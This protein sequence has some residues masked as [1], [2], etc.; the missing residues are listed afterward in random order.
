M[1]LILVDIV[2]INGNILYVYRD[3]VEGDLYGI[4]Q[5]SA[6]ESGTRQL[7]ATEEKPNIIL[8]R[9]SDGQGDK[10]FVID[11]RVGINATVIDKDHNGV[12]LEVD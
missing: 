2:I 1:K 11:D 3:S 12:I 9:M 6:T 4:R 10:K 8:Q 5:L 7:Y